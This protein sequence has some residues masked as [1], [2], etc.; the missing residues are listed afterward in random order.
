MINT[1]AK[2]LGIKKFPFL[3]KDNNSNIIYYEDI[4]GV[5]YKN[6]YDEEDNCIYHETSSKYWYRKV[7]NQNSICTYHEDSDGVIINSII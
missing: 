1:I 2:Q 6:E 4:Y 7:Y 3:I 5:W